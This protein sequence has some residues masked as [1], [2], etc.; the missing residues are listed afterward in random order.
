MDTGRTRVIGTFTQIS[1]AE[2]AVRELESFGFSSSDIR[3]IPNDQIGT[4]GHDDAMSASQQTA[5]QS[6]S[7]SQNY[8]EHRGGIMNFFSRLF[9][10]DD[11]KVDSSNY[12][13]T[14]D[15]DSESRRY[16]EDHYQQRRHL[17]LVNATRDR[18]EAIRILESCGG[19]VEEQASEFYDQELQRSGRAFGMNEAQSM[20]LREEELRMRKEAV[21]TGEVS[22]RKEVVTE[23]RNIEVPVSREEVVIE[24]HRLSADEVARAGATGQEISASAEREEIRIPVSEERVIVDKTVVPREEVTVSTRRVEGTE[25]VS[26]D[27]KREEVRVEREGDADLAM[28]GALGE[29][30]ID[31]EKAPIDFDRPLDETERRKKDRRRPTPGQQPY[32]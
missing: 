19:S 7:W 12:H 26:E 30:S 17:V 14:P 5:E 18:S 13:R 21:Q 4:P 1:D 25:R 20:E 32:V 9:G 24:R 3:F 2:R 23:T 29:D 31:D 16:F 11:S 10:L 6:S 8:P 15:Q 22:L 27:V 28:Q